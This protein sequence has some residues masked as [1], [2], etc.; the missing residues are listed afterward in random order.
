V[1]IHELNKRVCTP[2]HIAFGSHLR[3][4]LAVAGN[5]C[6]KFTRKKKKQVNNHHLQNPRKE[7]GF[8]KV[9]NKIS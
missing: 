7:K 1:Q 4:S 3:N 2:P 9:P 6:V 8:G 5:G